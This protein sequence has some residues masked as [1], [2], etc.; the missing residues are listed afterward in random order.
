MV[1]SVTRTPVDHPAA[2]PGTLATPTAPV[3]PAVPELPSLARKSVIDETLVTGWSNRSETS[4]QV[5]VQW[6]AEHTL[7]AE[8]GHY[9]PLLVAESMRQALTVLTYGVHG[10]PLGHRLGMERIRLA[11]NPHALHQEDGSPV[12][13]LLVRHGEVRRR[14][15]GSAHFVSQVKA[16]RAGQRCGLA[17]VHYSTHPPALY[18]RLRG[19]HADAPAAF[20]RALP[21]GPP[22][23]AAQ[24]GRRS[25]RNVVLS[26]TGL[27]A[28]WQLRLDTGHPVLFDH[29]HDH[30]PGMVLLEAAA[31]AA[32]AVLGRPVVPAALDATFLRYV[33]FDQP[34]LVAAEPAPPGDNG[35]PRVRVRGY[36]DGRPVFAVN[37]IATPRVA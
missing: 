11:T 26:P 3:T 28:Q 35:R 17:E 15:G 10:I 22:V 23:P 12:V 25:A 29:P 27:P 21:P 1:P 4:Q 14:R 9:S 13:D 33:E 8:D 37:V 32:S 6:P 20:A 30:V 34:C 16:V 5:T 2:T 36:Q 18:D 24:V 31:Q 19:R 7:Y